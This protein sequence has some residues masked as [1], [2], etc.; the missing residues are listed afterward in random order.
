M[1]TNKAKIPVLI[2]SIKRRQTKPIIRGKLYNVFEVG[3]SYGHVGKQDGKRKYKNTLRGILGN[4]EYLK[5]I[6]QSPHWEN[7][8]WMKRRRRWRVGQTVIW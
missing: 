6:Q 1:W 3:K 2:H 4:M 8:M 5:G 7:K